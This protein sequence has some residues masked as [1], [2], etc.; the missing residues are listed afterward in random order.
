MSVR[1]LFFVDLDDC[2][3]QT[4]RKN[5]DL[6]GGIASYARDGAPLSHFSAKQRQL[7][8][9]I[10]ATTEAIP[11]TARNRDAFERVDIAFS[12]YAI[13]SFGGLVLTPERAPEPSW[14]AHIAAA[15][16]AAGSELE[17]LLA[18]VWDDAKAKGI[19]IRARVIVDDGNA[20]YLSV[21]HNQENAAELA[22]LVPALKAAVPAGWYLHVNDNNLACLPPFLGKEH[23]VNHVR[24]LIGPDRLALGIGDSLT[25][26]GFL[27]ACDVTAMPSASQIA[28]RLHD[29]VAS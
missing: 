23:A 8:D 6:S 1:P 19:D 18:G 2:L 11:T 5:A 29:A 15:S 25:D 14:Q 7:V 3:F 16:R 21:K 22:L 10:L 26:A 17:R 28:Q 20:L 24:G 13:C 27:R 4:P 12:S 9:W